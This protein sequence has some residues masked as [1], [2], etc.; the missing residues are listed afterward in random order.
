MNSWAR[1]NI[2]PELSYPE[3]NALAS[4]APV[5]ADGMLVLPFGNGAERVLANRSTGARMIGIDLVRHSKAHILR[6]IQEGIA[7]SFRY[8]IDIMKD[9]A[10]GIGCI[11]SADRRLVLSNCLIGRLNRLG[12]HKPE[13][14]APDQLG[15]L[16]EVRSYVFDVLKIGYSAHYFIRHITSS[17]LRRY[18]GEPDLI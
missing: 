18:R 11:E 14:D 17:P 10:E 5:G 9:L 8:G 16:V 2:S 1:R 13:P 3:M 12:G 15:K 6:A 7:F 4:T